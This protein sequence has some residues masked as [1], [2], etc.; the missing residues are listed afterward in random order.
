MV[1][2]ILSGWTDEWHGRL[3]LVEHE[4]D[5]RCWYLLPTPSWYLPPQKIPPLLLLPSTAEDPPLLK[6]GFFRQVR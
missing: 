5:R 6:T 2:Q 1:L 4:A 3:L